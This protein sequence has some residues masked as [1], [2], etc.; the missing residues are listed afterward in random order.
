[1][2]AVAINTLTPDGSGHASSPML[3][4]VK[5]P[6]R[7]VSNGSARAPALQAELADVLV[8]HNF[9]FVLSDPRLPDHPI[10]FAS[11]GFCQ[12]TGY[13][14]E[15]VIGKNCRFLQGQDT[16]RGTVLEIRD[17][18][19]EERACQVKVL[20]YTK[21]RQPFWNL[22]HLA[23]IYSRD[24][25]RVLHFLGLTLQQQLGVGVGWGREPARRV[26]QQR[27]QQQGSKASPQARAGRRAAAKLQLSEAAVM[28]R[29]ER[30]PG[31]TAAGGSGPRWLQHLMW[32]A[33]DAARV[34]ASYASQGPE[35]RDHDEGRAKSAVT[36]VLGDLAEASR[37]LMCQER[38]VALAESASRGVVCSSLLM[39]LVRIQQSF[40]LGEAAL[41]CTASAP[42]LSL[43]S[44]GL[45]PLARYAREEVVG[46]NCRFLQ[47]PLTDPAA[48]RQASSTWGDGGGEPKHIL[49]D[50]VKFWNS[51]HIS[52]VAFFCGVQLDISMHQDS[53]KEVVPGGTGMS[54]R[55]QQLGAVGAVKVAVRGLQ[56]QGLRRSLDLP[57][58]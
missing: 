52:P 33:S 44:L 10:V 45:L 20:N 22:F 27:R 2:A 24:D 47:G 28:R 36:A 42:Y 3:A 23:P 49:K 53:S 9:N 14:K 21:A 56:G 12:M 25:G 15:E 4:H 29:V 48:V 46:R 38:R 13:R 34:P 31:E 54:Q 7:R 39:P 58:Q 8:K 55:M 16:D 19:R 35:V 26:Q 40:V 18:I 37:A 50:G 51:L 17:A 5:E 1:M 11:E 32:L 57:R 43:L 41:L 30:T 6:E